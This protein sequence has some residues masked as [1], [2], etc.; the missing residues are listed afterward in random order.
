MPAG[1][2][3]RSRRARRWRLD[4]DPDSGLTAL[5]AAA[6][7]R[8]RQPAIELT[9]TA[10]FAVTASGW[11]R[12]PNERRP[13]H[14][15][16]GAASRSRPRSP[17]K[18]RRRECGPRPAWARSR[19][20]RDDPWRTG[21]ATSTSRWVHPQLRRHL[22]AAFAHRRTPARSGTAMRGVATTTGAAPQCSG[23]PRSSRRAA[24]RRPACR[25]AAAARRRT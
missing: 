18:G 15:S 13:G 23:V 21:A 3:G 17:D 4:H 22:T 14:A 16:G 6:G 12:R 11:R 2:R 10:L 5:C 7:I 8:A 19:A 24:V 25:S 20:H 9:T 1:D